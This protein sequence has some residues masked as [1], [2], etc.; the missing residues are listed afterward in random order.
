MDKMREGLS[1]LATRQPFPDA[2]KDRLLI[3]DE[4]FQRR[5]IDELSE[6][7]KVGRP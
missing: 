7:L 6:K 4:D 2:F 3:T 5:W 1:Q